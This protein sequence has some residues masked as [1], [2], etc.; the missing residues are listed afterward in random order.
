[1]RFWKF[2]GG[3]GCEPFYACMC[4]NRSESVAT[5]DSDGFEQAFD[6]YYIPKVPE[7][8]FTHDIS[9]VRLQKMYTF[10]DLNAF[11]SNFTYCN[12]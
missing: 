5:D 12:L 1:M 6:Q 9:M 10:G 4:P 2:L 11:I 8:I 3:G 7:N